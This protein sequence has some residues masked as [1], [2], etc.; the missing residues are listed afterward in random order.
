[1]NVQDTSGSLL[2]LPDHAEPAT[3]ENPAGQDPV[4]MDVL[5]YFFLLHA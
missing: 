2:D 4:W 5:K 1:M 3:A